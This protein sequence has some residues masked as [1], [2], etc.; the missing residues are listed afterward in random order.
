MKPGESSSR[1]DAL[2]KLRAHL[3]AANAHTDLTP[4]ELCFLMLKKTDDWPIGDDL[5]LV[6]MVAAAFVSE[7]GTREATLQE[8]ALATCSMCR[9]GEW[10]LKFG[11]VFEH[12]P[13]IPPE[14]FHLEVEGAIGGVD[15]LAHKCLAAHIHAM[16]QQ[17]AERPDS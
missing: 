8:V 3:A 1:S 13:S 11:R 7:R 4:E 2:T 15:D 10:P 14:W 9:S 6:R 16:K 12:A 5:R 17:P